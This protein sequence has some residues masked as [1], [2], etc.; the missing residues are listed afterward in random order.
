M[1]YEIIY[2]IRNLLGIIF[3]MNDFL[4]QCVVI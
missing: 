4:E 2:E 1:E 3:Y